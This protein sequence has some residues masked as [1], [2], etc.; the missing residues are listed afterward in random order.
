MKPY[1]LF[2]GLI[3]LSLFTACRNRTATD[4]VREFYSLGQQSLE[5]HD[6]PQA[7][8]WFRNA[9]ETDDGTVDRQVMNE[10]FL[11][12][13]SLLYECGL[14]DQ[15]LEMTQKVIAPT[16]GPSAGT[17][18]TEACLTAGRCLYA[19]N[20][21][22]EADRLFRQATEEALVR[23]DTMQ[24][25]E[26]QSEW[27]ARSYDNNDPWQTVRLLEKL[28]PYHP[29]LHTYYCALGDISLDQAA[30]DSAYQAF[31]RLYDCPNLYF[32]QYGFARMAEAQYKLGDLEKA[33]RLLLYAFNLKDSLYAE[34][35][36]T[37][38]IKIHSLYDYNAQQ[39][40]REES[41]RES[42][43]LLLA[44]SGLLLALLA[45]ILY[46][47]HRYRRRMADKE[48][49]I[50]NVRLLLNKVREKQQEE[51][52]KLRPP[53][54]R[55]ATPDLSGTPLY[56]RFASSAAD[57][58]SVSEQDW[59]ALTE[60]LNDTSPDFLLK[61]RGLA[62]LSE[63][64]LRISML[65]RLHFSTSQIAAILHR[66]PSAISAARRRL[67]EK[68]TGKEGSA[69]DWDKIVEHL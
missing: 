45:G 24:W 51:Q 27:A 53:T 1:S 29:D 47:R 43:N 34:Q 57:G 9:I 61:L 63:M 19:I 6:A 38:I 44:T 13:A 39:K 64:E 23:G 32:R 10:I 50:Q 66:S 55:K 7:D 25:I 36:S 14:Y 4:R 52:E 69:G 33:Y 49:Q 68:A 41:E 15:A 3:F 46:L 59:R 54:E 18:S 42:R 11:Q 22:E 37:D 12:R 8:I 5:D 2:I 16:D 30:Y 31:A 67:F 17:L 40:L 62:R 26:L 60:T 20:Q 35:K 56:R 21:Q 58:A 48:R 65:V 28:S